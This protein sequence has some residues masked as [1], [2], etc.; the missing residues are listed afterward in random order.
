MQPLYLKKLEITGELGTNQPV[1]GHWQSEKNYIINC[2][3]TG[4]DILNLHSDQQRHISVESLISFFFVLQTYVNL[5][6]YDDKDYVNFDVLTQ[7]DCE[8]MHF[9]AI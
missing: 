8:Y 7:N 9:H 6:V 1:T 3:I 4:I 5:E 2:I